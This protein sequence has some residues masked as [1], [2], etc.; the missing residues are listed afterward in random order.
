MY[1]YIYTHT[2]VYIRTNIRTYI[3]TFHYEHTHIYL[4][5]YIC[6]DIHKCR[7]EKQVFKEDRLKI[8]SRRKIV[9]YL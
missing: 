7:N 5:A 4:Y 2:Y 3:H 9:L 1:I 6:K 8:F